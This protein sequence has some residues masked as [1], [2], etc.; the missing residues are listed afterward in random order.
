MARGRVTGLLLV[1]GASRRFGAPKALASFDGATL[2]ER[3]WATL[4][5]ACDERLAVGK[6]RDGLAL[7]FPL[8]DDDSDVR[9][10]LAGLVAGLRH[11]RNEVVVALPVDTPLLEADDVRALAA[12]CRD[13]AVVPTGPLPGAYAKHALPALERALDEERLT[14][15]D[16]VSELDAAVVDIPAARL[17]NVNTPDDL[18]ALTAPRVVELRAEQTDAFRDFVARSL[19]EFGFEV[20]AELDPDL[21]GGIDEY[22]AA[23][24]VLDGDDVVGSVVL[25]ERAARTLFLRRMYLAPQLRGRGVGR[26][27]LERA[28]VWAR[29]HGYERVRLD[30]TDAM[31]AARALYESAGF[32]VVGEGKPRNGQR[33]IEY[34][35]EL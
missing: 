2:A 13:A 24:V 29:E 19:R 22:V 15:R 34:A 21:A 20:D 25:I 11:A 4:G 17:A 26:A 16:V 6:Q 5:E 31:V 8:L 35:L 28:L 32:R 30:T 33:R 10:P 12:G 18:D 27:L 1:G 23:W 9:A 3:A 14:L 7:P